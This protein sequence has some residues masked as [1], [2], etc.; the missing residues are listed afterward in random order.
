MTDTD[1]KTELKPCPFCGHDA[2]LYPVGNHT[3]WSG[4]CSSCNTRGPIE[5]DK[6]YAIRMWNARTP[7]AA[8]K[9][10]EAL[11]AFTPQDCPKTYDDNDYLQLKFPFIQGER[12]EP[13]SEIMRGRKAA[14]DPVLDGLTVGSYRRARAALADY[15]AGKKG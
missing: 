12:L 11:E 3:H 15:R 8:D 10:A 6:D 4:G 9:L 1:S 7:T 13:R 14:F 2:E 5:K